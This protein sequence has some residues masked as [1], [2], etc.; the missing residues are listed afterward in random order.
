[1]SGTADIFFSCIISLVTVE[2]SYRIEFRV[3]V[4]HRENI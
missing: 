3:N 2:Y 1:M 4:G